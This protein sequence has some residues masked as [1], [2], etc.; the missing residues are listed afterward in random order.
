MIDKQRGY[1]PSNSMKEL[2]G[3]NAMLLPAISRFDIAFGF[4]DGSIDKICRDNSVDTGTFISVCD[5]LSGYDCSHIH[6]SLPS[7][8]GYLKRAH[9]LPFSVKSLPPSVFYCD[10]HG[11]VR[12]IKSPDICKCPGLYHLCN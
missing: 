12:K 10:G 6:I 1:M 4:G 3:D 11:S 5:L 2:I 9:T 7:L 8:M